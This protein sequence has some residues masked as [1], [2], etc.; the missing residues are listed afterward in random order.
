MRRLSG[1]HHDSSDAEKISIVDELC[2]LFVETIKLVDYSSPTEIRPNDSYVMLAA[3]LLW[4]MWVDSAEDKFFWKA[5]VILQSALKKSPA[6][7]HFR[8]LLIKF[9][10][11]AGRSS[12]LNY[13][14]SFSNC[15]QICLVS[16]IIFPT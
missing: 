4:Q 6:N 7:Y 11:Q 12:T 14:R 5:V 8:F 3:H 1:L 15:F 2:R 10:N 9:F 13:S 16:F